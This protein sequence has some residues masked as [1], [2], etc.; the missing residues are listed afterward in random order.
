MKLLILLIALLACLSANAQDKV[1]LATGDTVHCKISGISSS[2]IFA[3]TNSGRVK[4]SA[5]QVQSYYYKGEW[6]VMGSSSEEESIM[7]RKENW[8]PQVE[9]QHELHSAGAYFIGG[10]VFAA[11]ATIASIVVDDANAKQYLSLGA[12]VVFTG[13]IVLGGSKLQ[14]ASSAY[15][16]TLP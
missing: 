13:G 14:A 6:Q 4:Y 12:V 15:K 9:F 3:K 7:A 5:D 16:R 1:A 11:L 2:T 10:T 8:T